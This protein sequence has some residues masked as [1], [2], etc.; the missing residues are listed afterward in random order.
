MPLLHHLLLCAALEMKDQT[1]VGGDVRSK[2]I[3]SIKILHTLIIL[4]F[5][6]EYTSHTLEK[7]NYGRSKRGILEKP[8]PC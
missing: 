2:N 3:T 8:K 7:P 5:Q 6:N 4:A 1:T